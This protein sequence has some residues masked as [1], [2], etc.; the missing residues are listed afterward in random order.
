LY[1]TGPKTATPS[2]YETAAQ[3]RKKGLTK[4]TVSDDDTRMFWDKKEGV[5]AIEKIEA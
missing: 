3:T 1:S 2:R 4:R 5:H